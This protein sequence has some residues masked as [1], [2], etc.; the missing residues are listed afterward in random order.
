VFAYP[1]NPTDFCIVKEINRNTCCLIS[2]KYRP[3][4]L[5]VLLCTAVMA[6]AQVTVWP[7]DVNQNGIVNN[8]DL[9]P[10]GLGYNFFGP[11]RDSINSD[12]TMQNAAP[13]N[14]T[15][16]NGANFANGDCNGDGLINY[17]YDAFPIYVHYG[18]THGTVT[19]DIFQTGTPGID[20]SLFLDGSVLQGPVIAG[21]SIEVPLNLGTSALPVE[22]LY[23][24]VFSIHVDPIVI[25]ID[26]TQIDFSQ[27]SW[28]N[29]DQDRIFSVYRVSSSRLDVSW[30]RTDRNEKSGFGTI[31][32]V[33]FIIIDDVVTLQIPGTT[34]TIDSIKMI[35]RFGNEIAIASSEL[36]VEMAPNALSS[37]QQPA[38][39]G[40]SLS[41]NP[42]AGLVYIESAR[43]VLRADL[44]NV[45]GALAATIQPEKEQ[46]HW[47][48]QHL[49]NGIYYCEI[50]TEKAVIRRK[51]IIQH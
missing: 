49:P 34:I 12:F 28:A 31:A 37:E 19:P 41:P 22:D 27:L 47:P 33:D 42:T 17:F 11:A 10:I 4:V 5:L 8:V 13:W 15:F 1:P 38:E 40:I 30:V 18:N 36:Y 23:G 48:L 50:Q 20:P 43:P 2:M 26:Q 35:D 14:F 29:P 32:A 24:I 25:D 6:S 51:V 39:T 9:L 16:P 46:F 21:S 44:Y 45:T 7:G 3:S